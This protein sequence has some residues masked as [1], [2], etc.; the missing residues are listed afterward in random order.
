M[1]ERRRGTIVNV[2]SLAGAFP[3]PYLAAYTAAKA[4]LSGFTQSLMLTERG[5]GVRLIDFQPGD[6]RTAFN[7]AMARATELTPRE[8]QAWAHLEQ[9]LQAAPPPERAARDLLKALGKRRDGIVR[10]GGFFQT[11]VAPLGLR[12]LPRVWLL[13]IIRRYYGITGR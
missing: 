13:G 7:K 5:T 3:L 6:F 10:S 11:H 8:Q 9:H 4:G 12:L 2:S 1:R